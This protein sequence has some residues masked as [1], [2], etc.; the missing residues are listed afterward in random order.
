MERK[1]LSKFLNIKYIFA[2]AMV[3]IFAGFL[4]Y[5]L[6]GAFIYLR[7]GRAARINSRIAQEIFY[8][9]FLNED[10]GTI[11]FLNEARQTTQNAEV[12]GF[13]TI[14]GTNIGDFVTQGVDNEFY[15]T[16]DAYG[17]QNSNCALFCLNKP[18]SLWL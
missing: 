11:S 12:V 9:Y 1:K 14:A 2:L 10:I 3:F 18:R 8:E 5:S 15:L 7:D 16:H 6:F 17:N 13:V 4:I